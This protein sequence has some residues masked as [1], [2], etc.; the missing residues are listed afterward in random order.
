[1]ALLCMVG[2]GFVRVW[3]GVEPDLFCSLL[4]VFCFFVFVSH[5]FDAGG[6]VVAVADEAEV[7]EDDAD[8]QP[9]SCE[10]D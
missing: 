8:D 5:F 4:T 3:S 6:A 7:F 1:M 2:F 9:E 10:E